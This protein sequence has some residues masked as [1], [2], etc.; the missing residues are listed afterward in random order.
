MAED[1]FR[2]G[3]V[4]LAV[5][6]TCISRFKIYY[7]IEL[8]QLFSLDNL[9]LRPTKKVLIQVVFSAFSGKGGE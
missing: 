4:F 7:I 3:R 8:L 5:E 2:Y 6:K 9:Y 1:A